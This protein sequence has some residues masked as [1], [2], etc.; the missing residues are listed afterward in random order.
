MPGTSIRGPGWWHGSMGY[1]LVGGNPSQI[2]LVPSPRCRE[3]EGGS[4]GGGVT[5]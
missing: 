5:R 2:G 1:G 4:G 3:R